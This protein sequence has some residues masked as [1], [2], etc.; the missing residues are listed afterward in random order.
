MHE[1]NEECMTKRLGEEEREKEKKRDKAK[2][3]DRETDR[4]MEREQG[5]EGGKHVSKQVSHQ[6]S[7]G[8]LHQYNHNRS[9]HHYHKFSPPG[10]EGVRW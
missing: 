1:I 10:S 7:G 8:D 3:T 2:Q 5:G 9:E 6:V 4:Q